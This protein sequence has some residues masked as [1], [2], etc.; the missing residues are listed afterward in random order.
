MN[1]PLDALLEEHGEKVRAVRER[2]VELSKLAHEEL[3]A[4]TADQK[5]LTEFHTLDGERFQEVSLEGV[6]T[7]T[8]PSNSHVLRFLS[9]YKFDVERAA[10]H[11][12]REQR[13]RLVDKVADVRAKAMKAGLERVIPINIRAAAPQTCQLGFSKQGH[14]ITLTRVGFTK[15]KALLRSL[16][17]DDYIKYCFEA[18]EIICENM[19]R[20]GAE[21]GRL[22]GVVQILDL[23][24]L[25]TK[26]MDRGFINEYLRS[27]IAFAS[28]RYVEMV[29]RTLIVNAPWIFSAMWTMCKGF[30]NEAQRQKVRVC[31]SGAKSE[32][33]LLNYIPKETLPSFLYGER[34]VP[35][36]EPEYALKQ[37]RAIELPEMKPRLEAFF[38]NVGKSCPISA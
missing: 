13:W 5:G 14:I 3:L 10:L 16:T 26:H 29:Y 30:L 33:E 4:A 20:A 8:A 35:Y 23:A 15:P 7:A 36:L 28:E 25:G 19:D 22:M 9:G 6:V 12:V 17:P 34:V 1:Q 32:A 38:H 2:A 11:L 21:T 18:N 24:G 37:K 31:T 27:A